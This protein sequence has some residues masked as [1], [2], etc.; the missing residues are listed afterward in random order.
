MA[1]EGV[2]MALLTGL[3]ALTPLANRRKIPLR[4]A[5]P[6]GSGMLSWMIAFG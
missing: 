5:V 6:T 4:G 1:L 2:E 3:S